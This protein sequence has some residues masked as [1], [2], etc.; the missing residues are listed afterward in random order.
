MDAGQKGQFLPSVPCTLSSVHITP[1][2]VRSM[3]RRLTYELLAEHIIDFLLTCERD[4]VK[5]SKEQA[6]ANSGIFG[7]GGGSASSLF[8]K[9][10]ESAAGSTAAASAGAGGTGSAAGGKASQQ[11]EKER[12]EKDKEAQ[13]QLRLLPIAV[14]VLM[15]AA[16]ARAAPYPVVIGLLNC[17][18]PGEG[19]ACNLATAFLVIKRAVKEVGRDNNKLC[20]TVGAA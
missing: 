14:N 3:I 20:V 10:H 19:D 1:M 8:A 15:E 5:E 12:L 17:L 4:R 7:A 2:Q 16:R 11:L 18:R 13:Q 6:N 9:A